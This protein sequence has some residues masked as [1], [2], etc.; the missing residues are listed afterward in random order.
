M[1]PRMKNLNNKPSAFEITYVDTNDSHY[2]N[3]NV[4]TTI[5]GS[6]GKK[7]TK[8]IKGGLKKQSMVVRGAPGQTQSQVSVAFFANHPTY[9]LM[10]IVPVKTEVDPNALAL[11]L[12]PVK[13]KPAKQAKTFDPRSIA[14]VQAYVVAAQQR[15]A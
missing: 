7:I 4:Q 11:L 1:E 14:G 9:K 8:S 13:V 10:G 15:A 6:A 12:S 3:R 2:P 5:P